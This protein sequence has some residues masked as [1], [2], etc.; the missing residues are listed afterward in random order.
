MFERWTADL[1]RVL[2]HPGSAKILDACERALGL[3]PEMTRLSRE[4]LARNGNLSSS[5]LLFILRDALE[6]SEPRPGSFGLMAAFGPGF[7]CELVLLR[8]E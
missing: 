2:L 8:F 5:S 3:P 4:F 6:K 7:A 1:E